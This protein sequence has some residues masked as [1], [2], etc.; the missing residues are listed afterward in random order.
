M[1]ANDPAS[2]A[3]RDHARGPASD[4]ACGPARGPARGPAS[5]VI[6]YVEAVQAGD[7]D[8]ARD[9]FAEDATWDYPGDL[10]L[11]GMWRG[12]EAI[13][14]DFLGGMHA[15]LEPGSWVGIELTSIV[16]QGD[17]AVAEWTSRGTARG[18]ARYH[19]RCAGVF[20]V[21][22]GKISS[23]REYLDTQHVARVLFPDARCPAGPAR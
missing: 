2:N 13:I 22:D 11:S 3:V 17:Q 5:V 8:T 16:S 10:P 7:L 14:G 4:R 19:N 12:R 6:R 18:G 9:C 15:L 23:V 1:T 21:R 20:T